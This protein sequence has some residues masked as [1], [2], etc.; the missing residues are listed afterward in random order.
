MARRGQLAR[1]MTLMLPFVRMVVAQMS[2]ASGFLL[3]FGYR[4]N[5]A[6][7]EIEEFFGYG[8][9]KTTTDSVPETANHN[10]WY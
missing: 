5:I 2:P 3:A 4:F 8:E 6:R 7:A 10:R 9:A 1:A